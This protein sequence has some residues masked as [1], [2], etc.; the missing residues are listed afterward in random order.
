M[1]VAAC[2]GALR[3]YLVEQDALPKTSLVAGMPVSLKS[4]GDE[5]W[6]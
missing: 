2:G 1:L 4:A 5:G 3:R 6:Q